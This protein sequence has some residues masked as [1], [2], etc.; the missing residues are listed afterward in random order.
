MSSETFLIGLALVHV[1]AAAIV[2][3]Q[4]SLNY[5]IGY[6]A[7][8]LLTTLAL[9]FVSPIIGVLKLVLWLFAIQYFVRLFNSLTILGNNIEVSLNAI[10]VALTRRQHIIPRMERYVGGYAHH[11][12]QTFRQTIQARGGAARN[13]LALVEA[14]PTLRANQTFQSLLAELVEAENQVYARRISFN[15]AIRAYNTHLLQFP[16]VIVAGAMGFAK[17]DYETLEQNL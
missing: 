5:F 6:V 9:L 15:E 10:R 1:V 7:L 3:S 16:N 12:R 4:R 11:E 17:R 13:L 8:S 14:Y 2:I